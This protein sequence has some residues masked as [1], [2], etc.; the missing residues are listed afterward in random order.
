MSSKP[1]APTLVMLHGLL[2]DAQDWGEVIAD[3]EGINS[4]ALDLPGH[5]Q[6]QHEQVGSLRLFTTGLAMR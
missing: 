1:Q 5:G 6:N 4:L 2:G 3:L